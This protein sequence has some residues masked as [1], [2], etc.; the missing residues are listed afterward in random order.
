M[1]Y[2]P[3]RDSKEFVE[4]L[5]VDLSRKRDTKEK[6]TFEELTPRFVAAMLFGCIVPQSVLL[7]KMIWADPCSDAFF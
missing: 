4:K 3:K 5:K 6:K 7:Y 2:Q 1:F